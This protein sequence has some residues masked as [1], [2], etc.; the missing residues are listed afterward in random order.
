MLTTPTFAAGDFGLTD[1]L[2][3][4][5]ATIGVIIAGTIFLQ[6]LS[7]KYVELSG[8]YRSLT[9]EYRKGGAGESRHSLLQ[10]QIGTYRRRLFLLNRASWLACVALLCFLVAVLLGGLSMVFPTAAAVKWAGTSGLFAGL[11]L[12]AGGVGL[13]LYESVLARFEIG[14]EVGDLDGPAGGSGQ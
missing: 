3:S 5:G 8:R 12:I 1:L 2:G 7:S 14:E 9:G 4:A 10:K 13:E 11:A 6:F